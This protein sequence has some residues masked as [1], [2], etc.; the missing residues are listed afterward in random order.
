[1]AVGVSEGR[2]FS[3]KSDWMEF[4]FNNDGQLRSVADRLREV[5]SVK[6]FGAV[7]DG[8]TDDTA[9]I[10]KALDIGGRVFFPKGIYGISAPLSITQANTEIEGEC[11]IG[12]MI[13]PLADV[14]SLGAINSI[15]KVDVQPLNGAIRNIRFKTLGAYTG[16]AIN[17]GVST[18]GKNLFSTEIAN[19]WCDFASTAA[20]F[21]KG[22]MYDCWVHHCQFENLQYRFLLEGS[23]SCGNRTIISQCNDIGGRLPFIETPALQNSGFI[24]SDISVSTVVG[25]SVLASRN[26]WIKARNSDGWTISNVRLDSGSTYDPVT[27]YSGFLNFI[28]CENMSVSTCSARIDDFGKSD[29][30]V[31]RID[32]SE[33]SVSG[34]RVVDNSTAR[35]LSTIVMQGARVDARFSGLDVK[36]GASDQIRFNSAAIA[37]RVEVSDSLFQGSKGRIISDA[38]GNHTL[39]F[40][41]KGNRFLNPFYGAAPAA[42]NYVFLFGTSGQTEFVGNT[43]G[44]D[45]TGEAGDLSAPGTIFRLIGSGVGK[46]EGNTLQRIS[47]ATWNYSTV[48]QRLASSMST[49]NQSIA[50]DGVIYLPSKTSGVAHVQC[51][52]EAAAFVFGVTA[53]SVT[54]VAGTTNTAASDLDGNLCAFW[55]SSNTIPTIKNRLGGARQI[56]VRYEFT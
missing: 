5:V 52:D 25:Q 19:V 31:L 26:Y 30:E 43:I 16:W 24:I 36:G 35:P 12:T 34:L 21:F 10:Q 7:G 41:A 55:T 6:D 49:G 20:G 4:L 14:T 39:D 28:D 13:C 40:Y 37:G 33:V 53:G 42:T 46:I 11:W 50:D 47:A 44:R 1:M 29:F 56:S 45:A 38:Y 17:A 23:S 27:S 18:T 9:A 32:N 15:I 54:K 3:F 22:G 8:V 2:F 48:S 51:G